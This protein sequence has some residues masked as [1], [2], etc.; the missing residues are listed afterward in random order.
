MTPRASARAAIL[1]PGLLTH[2]EISRLPPHR[3]ARILSTIRGESTHS[4]NYNN[5]RYLLAALGKQTLWE[6][7]RD[8]S[9]SAELI[10]KSPM[11]FKRGRERPALFDSSRRRQGR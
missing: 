3:E 11:P 2:E 10:E 8:C 6:A 1:I 5:M 9:L 7:Q 4:S